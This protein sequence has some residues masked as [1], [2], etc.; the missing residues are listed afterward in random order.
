[1]MYSH[2]W[3]E[4]YALVNF[5]QFGCQGIVFCSCAPFAGE[6]SRFLPGI[7]TYYATIGCECTVDWL[8]NN[9]SAI[10]YDPLA[11]IAD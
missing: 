10:S 4:Y 8:I 1:M 11:S 3:V 6:A 7:S 2:G 9:S 5:D